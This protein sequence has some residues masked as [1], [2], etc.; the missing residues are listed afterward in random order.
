MEYDREN[1]KL[2]LEGNVEI[3]RTP[4]II[5]APELEI[6]LKTNLAVAD[7]GVRIVRMEKY[8]EQEVILA[9]RAEINIDSQT[10]L[11]VKGRLV[12]PTNP[13]Q[14]S[15]PGK[16]VLPTDKGQITIEGERL[17][18]MSEDKYLFKTGSFTSCQCAEGKKPDWEIK[19]KEINADTKGSAKMKSAQILVREK[20]LLY[21]PYAEYPVT[22]DRKSGLLAPTFGYSSRYGYKVGLPYYQVLGPS[23]DTTLYPYWL[24]SRGFFVGDEFRHNLGG[25]SMGDLEGFA[26]EDS[27]EHQWRWSGN[28]SGE[29]SWKTGWLREDVNMISDNEYLLDFDQNLAYRWQ[30]ELD[31][32][33]LYSQ[34]L[35]GSNISAEAQALR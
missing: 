18:R 28:Y 5:Y 11:L 13:V 23:A 30:R 17:E 25:I 19:A 16:L 4:W 27:T 7:K 6:N 2:L 21:I 8:Q 15:G 31:S 22:T 34:D 20:A 9:D 26:I 33:I 24:S 29:S 1:E 35:P 3:H 12:L 10:G 14:T 32:S